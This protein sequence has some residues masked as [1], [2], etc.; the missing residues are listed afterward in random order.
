MHK[1]SS[2]LAN[3]KVKIKKHVVHPQFPSFGG[4]EILIE[5]WWDKLTGGS[6]MHT[7]GNPACMIYACRTGLCS[8]T[9]PTDDEVLYGKVGSY[10]H[11][12]HITELDV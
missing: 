10:G 8:Y 6:W 4:S 11:L 12:V 7:Y 2:P 1:Q 5:D 9:V 3:K